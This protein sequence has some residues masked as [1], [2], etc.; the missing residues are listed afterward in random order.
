MYNISITVLHSAFL[1]EKRF[2]NAF[3]VR[4]RIIAFVLYIQVKSI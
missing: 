1:Q 2:D 4:E 3:E